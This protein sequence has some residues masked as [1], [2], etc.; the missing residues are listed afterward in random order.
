MIYYL[1]C[2]VPCAVKLNGEYIGKA[3]DNYSVFESDGGLMELLPLSSSYLPVNCILDD[4]I[5]SPNMRF[6]DLGG[7]ILIIPVFARQQ[8]SD[9][10]ILAKKIFD[11]QPSKTAVTCYTENGARI[12]IENSFGFTVENLPFLPENI[13]FEL[14][15]T[16]RKD[17]IFISL[18]SSRSEVLAFSLLPEPK[19]ELRRK[20]DSFAV[21]G[22]S[23]KLVE[24]K[25]D[26]LNHTVTSIWN[27]G[28]EVKATSFAVEAKKNPYA[29]PEELFKIAFFEEILIG[30]NPEIFLSPSL[31]P[32]SNFLK[33]FLGNFEK[34]LPPPH[35]KPAELVLLLYKDKAA[36]A[37]V[38]MKNGLIDGLTLVD[39]DEI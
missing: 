19:L 37:D 6:F 4:G 3:T 10:R 28:D 11:A 18:S 30:G 36:Y 25:N 23:L 7:G 5:S 9:F 12:T 1:L 14:I 22:N 21:N 32:K 24:N 34:V 39:K 17:Y 16:K 31:K 20:A 35:F 13:T 27:F 38:K 15:K 29:L 33:D 8:F 26:V 2:P